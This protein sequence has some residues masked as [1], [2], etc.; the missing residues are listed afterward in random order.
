MSVLSACSLE[1]M[2]G[3][4]WR[5]STTFISYITSTTPSQSTIITI[6]ARWSSYCKRCQWIWFFFLTVLLHVST[7]KLKNWHGTEV[8]CPRIHFL[9]FSPEGC[10]ASYIV[11]LWFNLNV[12]KFNFKFNIYY[13]FWSQ[14]FWHICFSRRREW[15]LCHV[16]FMIGLKTRSRESVAANED[17]IYI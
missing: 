5:E 2:R 6:H 14:I 9:I 8:F 15:S 17:F 13:I 11:G 7:L 10:C 3:Q 4:L 12:R 1:S 16:I